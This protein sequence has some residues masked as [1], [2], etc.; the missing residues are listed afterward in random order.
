MSG[1]F[2]L[3][4]LSMILVF[5]HP[6]LSRNYLQAP[7]I[8]ILAYISLLSASSLCQSVT[9]SITAAWLKCL[10][11]N[12]PSETSKCGA[13]SSRGSGAHT[14]F[15]SCDLQPRGWWLCFCLKWMQPDKR[16]GEEHSKPSMS[17]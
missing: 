6:P 13:C 4:Q 16:T 10:S 8:Q 17:S 7:N 1:C 11:S 15:P 9:P 3:S 14:P 12:A 5:M 2:T